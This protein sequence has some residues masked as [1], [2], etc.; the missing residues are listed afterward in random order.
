M[1]LEVACHLYIY[2][3]SSTQRVSSRVDTPVMQEDLGLP[4][5]YGM[6]N[7]SHDVVDTHP[8]S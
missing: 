6:P 5:E 3:G 2:P 1:R 7:G 8:Y 4:A